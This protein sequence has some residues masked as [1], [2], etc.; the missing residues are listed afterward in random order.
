MA[1]HIDLHYFMKSLAY[2]KNSEHFKKGFFGPLPENRI[3]SEFINMA[4]D[5]EKCVCR[6]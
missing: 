3:C 4:N 2:D 5:H 1:S 6:P